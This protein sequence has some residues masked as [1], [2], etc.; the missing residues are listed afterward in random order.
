[1]NPL[2]PNC[3]AKGDIR[4]LLSKSMSTRIAKKSILSRAKGILLVEP[5][6]SLSGRAKYWYCNKCKKRWKRGAEALMRKD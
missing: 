1:M 3:K 5:K 4:F 6:D 2:C